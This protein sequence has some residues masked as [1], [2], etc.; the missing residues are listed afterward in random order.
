L[1]LI[2]EAFCAYISA[3]L[4]ENHRLLAVLESQVILAQI[5]QFRSIILEKNN[6]LKSLAPK[7]KEQTVEI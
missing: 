5:L 1:I 4:K 2:T 3:E 6:F 7:M